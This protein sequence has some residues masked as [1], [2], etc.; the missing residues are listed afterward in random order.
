M[1]EG[2]LEAEEAGTR[3][4]VDQLGAF[5]RELRERGTKVVHL[6]GDVMHARAALREK[7]TDGRLLAERFQQLDASV[8]NS[9]RRCTHTLLVDR[10]LMLD[11]GAEEPLVG[12]E[13]GIEIVDR[14]SEMMNA[15]RRHAG[16]ATQSRRLGAV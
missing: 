14:H 1:D 9:Q 6:G 15:A 8:A 12:L 13:G 11:L 5:P 2:H 3:L 16:D 10:R 7:A 4:F